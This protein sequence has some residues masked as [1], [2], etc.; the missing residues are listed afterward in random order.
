MI[1]M[2][3]IFRG[4]YTA[5][6]KPWLTRLEFYTGSMDHPYLDCTPNI[7]YSSPLSFTH[8]PYNRL[9]TFASDNSPISLCT[10]A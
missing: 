4:D 6:T 8:F 2:T 10:L 7:L 5:H 9:M 1:L 3:Q